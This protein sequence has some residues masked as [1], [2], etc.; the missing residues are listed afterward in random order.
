METV[1][2]LSTLYCAYGAHSGL[3][4]SEL[5]ELSLLPQPVTAKASAATPASVK[6]RR[7]LERTAMVCLPLAQTRPCQ[8]VRPAVPVCAVSPACKRL[9]DRLSSPSGPLIDNE[10][11]TCALHSMFFR[12]ILMDPTGAGSQLFWVAILPLWP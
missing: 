1:F 3:L 7:R 10:L 5:P 4:V 11:A 8:P 2:F 12:R 6:A 9:H